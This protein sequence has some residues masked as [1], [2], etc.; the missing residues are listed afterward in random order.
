MHFNAMEL[1]TTLQEKQ[2]KDAAAGKV[3]RSTPGELR[4]QKGAV[5]LHLP[6]LPGDD[7]T[8]LEF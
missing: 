3:M 2:K 5:Q 7:I 1:S 6:F 8:R 4:L